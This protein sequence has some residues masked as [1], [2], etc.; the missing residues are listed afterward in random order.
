[1]SVGTTIQTKTWL[2]SEEVAEYLGV[3]VHTVREWVQDGTMPFSRLGSKLLRF[4]R[5]KI[6]DWVESEDL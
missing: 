1:M 5:E 4:R 6:D 2:N 3:S